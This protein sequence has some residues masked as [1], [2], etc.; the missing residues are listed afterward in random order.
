[1]DRRRPSESCS[2]AELTSIRETCQPPPPGSEWCHSFNDSHAG[3]VSRSYPA[4]QT[5]R[6][7]RI[8]HGPLPGVTRL[9]GSQRAIVLGT[10]G[11]GSDI[12]L[13]RLDDAWAWKRTV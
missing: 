9:H 4:P 12:S 5:G 10:M 8:R 7:Q 6:C 3:G 13:S 1:M 2:M 11:E